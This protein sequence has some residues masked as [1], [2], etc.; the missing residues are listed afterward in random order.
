MQFNVETLIYIGLFLGTLLFV[1]GLYLVVFGATLT[2]ASKFNR[3]MAMLEAGK[4]RQDVLTTLRKEINKQSRTGKIP[5]LSGLLLLSRRAN[6]NLTLKVLVMAILG[7]AVAIFAA[8]SILTEAAFVLK[9]AVGLIG[10][11]VAVHS[12]ISNKAK[13]RIKLIEEQLPDAVELLVRSLRV[14]HPFSAA[15]AAI[16][17][18]IPDPLGTELGLIADEAAYGGD[19]AQGL[20]DLADRLDNQD[21]RFLA[22]SVSISQSS[23]GNLADVLDG[24]AKVIRARFKLF[25]RVQAITAE[26]KFSGKFLSSF[27][28]LMLGAIKLMKPDYFDGVQQSSLFIPGAITV[29]VLMAVNMFFMK[30]MVNIKV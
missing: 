15:L 30:L 21:L 17:Q 26:A 23:G 7:I 5:F 9:L 12:F 3:R 25:R 11:A 22:V 20:A 8:L 18:E 29:F 2:K 1:G 14:G 13:A 10:G 6:L 4:T 24:L 16:T 27:P 19:V 28:A